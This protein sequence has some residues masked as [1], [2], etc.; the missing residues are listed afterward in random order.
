[1]S[2]YRCLRTY[3]NKILISTAIL[4]LSTASVFAQQLPTEQAAPPALPSATSAPAPM[5]LPS[6]STQGQKDTAQPDVKLPAGA[7]ITDA[8]QRVRALAAQ[9]AKSL[10]ALVGNASDIART[11]N[12]VNVMSKRKIKAMELDSQI[13][14]AEKPKSF[15][16]S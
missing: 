13:E 7:T 11:N 16:R 1:M 6:A 4:C 8:D 10:D 12:D 2:N 15:G 3:K 5:A 14:L 9:N